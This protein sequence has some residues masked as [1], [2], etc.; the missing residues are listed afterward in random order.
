[1]KHKTRLA[2][3]RVGAY[4]V[5]D[6]ICEALHKLPKNEQDARIKKIRNIVVTDRRGSPKHVPYQISLNVATS[7]FVSRSSNLRDRLLFT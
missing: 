6:L 1:V 5:A 4:Q 2:K 3:E 7:I